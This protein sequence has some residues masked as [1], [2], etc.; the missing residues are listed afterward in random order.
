[1]LISL[2]KGDEAPKKAIKKGIE[3]EG[4]HGQAVGQKTQRFCPKPC[5]APSYPAFSVTG[6]A[7]GQKREDSVQSLGEV[8]NALAHRVGLHHFVPSG[9]AGLGDPASLS[10]ETRSS[11]DFFRKQSLRG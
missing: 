4:K 8:R 6:E 5:A 11:C 7:V 9:D 10:H 3:A 2:A 1:M